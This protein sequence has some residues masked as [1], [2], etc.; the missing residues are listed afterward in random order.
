[1]AKHSPTPWDYDPESDFHNDPSGIVYVDISAGDVPDSESRFARIDKGKTAKADAAFIVRAVNAH[2]ALVAACEA[3]VKV[4]E[5]FSYLPP[6][7]QK[8]LEALTAAL[9]LAKS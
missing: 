2:D 9:K 1:M 6:T 3:A 8:A 5:R 7:H 4:F